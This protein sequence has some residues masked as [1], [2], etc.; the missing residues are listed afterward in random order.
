MCVRVWVCARVSACTHLC[1]S[2]FQQ[3]TGH[4]PG[5]GDTAEPSQ[6]AGF[7]ATTSHDR[8]HAFRAITSLSLATVLKA[9]GPW[10]IG[11]PPTAPHVKGPATRSLASRV[12]RTR[13][14]RS[15][16]TCQVCSTP[17]MGWC[18]GRGGTGRPWLPCWHAALPRRA[19][20]GGHTP[21]LRPRTALPPQAP[22]LRWTVPD[23]ADW[24][25][26]GA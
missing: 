25:C 3:V 19:G 17:V 9:G 21:G 15:P 23:G 5:R 11:M 1:L 16:A 14:G 10:D 22:G 8:Q 24:P 12:G 2:T 13:L 4:S 18:L 7:L 26:K 20:R 6:G